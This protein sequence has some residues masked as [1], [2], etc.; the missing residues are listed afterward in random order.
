MMQI[1]KPEIINVVEIELPGSKSESNRALILQ[2]LSSEN[3]YINNLSNAEDT[4]I[5]QQALKDNPSVIDCHQS[6]AALRFLTAYFAC[7]KNL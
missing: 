4:I 7:Q 6:G 2:A 5:I 3:I 1:S